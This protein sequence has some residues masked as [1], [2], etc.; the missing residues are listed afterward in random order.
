MN[1]I[2]KLLIILSFT[3]TLNAN[4]N[5][6]FKSNISVNEF[7]LSKIKSWEAMVKKAEN[8]KT[9]KKYAK[10][11]AAPW[12]RLKEKCEITDMKLH[13]FRHLLGFT[14]VNNGVSLENISRALGH[15]KIATT[16]M[17]SNQKEKMASDAVDAY[18]DLMK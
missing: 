9:L 7:T 17:Y 5:L 6:D 1:I 15:S 13:D 3:L 18:L 4:I 10:F 8:K 14:L 11:P 12:K 16:Q 2:L